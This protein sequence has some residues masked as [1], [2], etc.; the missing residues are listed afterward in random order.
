MENQTGFGQPIGTSAPRAA[1]DTDAPRLSLNGTWR[2][3]LAPSVAESAEG[4]WEPDFDDTGWSDLPVPSSWPMHGH[5]RPAYTNV[6]YPF[7]VDPPHVPTDNPTGD[8]RLVFDVPAAFEGLGA[9]LRFDGIDSCGRVWLNGVELGVTQGSRLPAE[10]DVTAALRPGG[11]NVLAV[12]VHQWSAGS[13]L[14]DQD[15]WWLPGIFRDVTLLARPDGGVGD[16]FVHATFEPDG[17]GRLRV[18]GPADALVSIPELGL[19]DLPTGAGHDAGPVEPWTAETPRRYELIV[20]TATETATLRIGFRTVAIVGGILTVNGR[21]IVLRGVN[22]HEFHPELGRVVPPDVVRAELELMK[23]HHVNAIRTSHYPPHPAVLD[24]CDELGFWVIDECDYETHGF[25]GLGWRGNPSDDPRFAAALVDRMRRM[26][27]RDKNHPSVIMWSLGNEAGVGANLGLMA[28]WARERDPGRP[29]HYEGDRSCAH[30]DVYSRMYASH[31]EVDAIGRGESHVPHLPFILCEYAHAMGNGPGGLAEYDELFDRHPRCQGGFVWEWLD[32]GIRRPAGDYAY[33]GDFGEPLHDSNFVIDGLVFPDRTPS[34]GLTELGA[35]YAPVRLAARPGEVTVRNRYVFRSLAGVALRWTIAVEGVTVSEGTLGLPPIAPG[36]AEI[37]SLPIASVP[38]AAGEAWLTVDAVDGAGLVL[39]SG[40]VQLRAAPGWVPVS[41][42]LDSAPASGE[43]PSSGTA[44][45]RE[46]SA[47]TPGP[48]ASAGSAAAAG[49]SGL[50]EPDVGSEAASGAS[51]PGESAALGAS[52]SAGSAAAA[53]ASGLAEPDVGSEAASGASVP[54]ESAASGTS[55][56]AVAPGAPGVAQTSG[57]AEALEHQPPMPGA[58][59]SEALA[60]GVHAS[61]S[62]PSP[63]RVGAEE[64]PR[65]DGGVIRLGLAEFEPVHGRLTRLGG[66]SL[67]GPVLDVWRAPIDNDRLGPDPVADR[68]R[69]AGLH[70]MT[71]RLLG[72]E[73]TGDALVV[74]TRVAP[75]ASDRALLTWYT[76]RN[77]ERAL[78]LT[79]RVEPTGDWD[80]PLPRLGVRLELPPELGDVTWFG[81]GPGE[82]YPDS[83]TAA[84]IGRYESTVDGLATPYVYPQ[85]NGNRADARWLTLTGPDGG[86]LRVEGL[87]RIDFTA[88]RWSTAALDAALHRADLVPSDRIHLHLDHA[89]HGLGSAACGPGVLPQYVLHAAPATFAVVLQPLG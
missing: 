44:P 16:V 75:A 53:G 30:V 58:N 81:A 87:P 1:F 70:R 83:R 60:A 37:L 72:I 10:F 36:Q 34:P 46:D 7:P 42:A 15:M 88:R 86:G 21:R 50:A 3:R 22:R 27:E 28:D 85:E 54:G 76:W 2:F 49:A 77:R 39:G 32:H 71:H 67:N 82:A 23:R 73:L 38:S 56:S 18:E 6:V 48:L 43:T 68:W 31:A 89:H 63:T 4:F 24:L 5:G 19:A 62:L 64:G 65:W 45:I 55:A 61:A 20:A 35:V 51:V 26:V 52:A 9:R 47:T 41:P 57:S 84:L 40:Q 74:A 12:R 33:G 59:G 13:Y 14:E 69:A 17:R 11:V 66:L 79:L 78:E 29:L 25:E 80:I 8:H